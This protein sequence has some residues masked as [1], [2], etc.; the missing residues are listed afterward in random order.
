MAKTDEDW[1]QE[2]VD[3]ASEDGEYLVPRLVYLL[4]RD[5]EYDLLERAGVDNWEG[6]CLHEDD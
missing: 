1:L 2:A 6:Y 3:L 4:K 5:H